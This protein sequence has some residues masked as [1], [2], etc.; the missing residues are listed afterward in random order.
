MQQTALTLLIFIG[1]MTV[2]FLIMPTLTQH[3]R[4]AFEECL[5]EVQEKCKSIINYASDLEKEN[6]RLNL[7]CPKKPPVYLK[8]TIINEGSDASF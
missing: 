4:Q 8:P 2:A 7:S 6:A 3:D 1:G 5:V